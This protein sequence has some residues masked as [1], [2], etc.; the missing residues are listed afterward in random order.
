MFCFDGATLLLLQFRANTLEDIKD[1]RCPIDCWVFPA[2]SSKVPLRYALY[3]LLVQ[4]FRRFQGL[5]ALP[6]SIGGLAPIGRQLFDGL[7]VW[8]SEVDGAEVAVFD[9]PGGYQRSVD[10]ESGAVKWTHPENAADIVW[11]T[12]ALWGE[13]GQE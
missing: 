2:S 3:R 4:G 10:A 13:F 6:I 11:E 7:P 8:R 12:P 9:H 1:A 5:C